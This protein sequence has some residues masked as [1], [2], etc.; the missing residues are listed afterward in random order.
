[1]VNQDKSDEPQ[2]ENSMRVL[3]DGVRWACD[4]V[5]GEGHLS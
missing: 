4:F 1:M 5:M 2:D 3:K